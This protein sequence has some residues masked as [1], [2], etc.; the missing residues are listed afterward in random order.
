[1]KVEVLRGADA[2]RA[3]EDSAFRANWKSLHGLCPWS[4]VFQDVSFATTWYRV[5]RDVYEPVV[6]AGREVGGALSGLFLL[7]RERK[8]GALVHAGEKHAE[9]QTWISRPDRYAFISDAL[10]AIKP[11]AGGSTLQLRYVPSTLPLEPLTSSGNWGWRTV[12]WLEERGIADLTKA[13]G[14]ASL[15]D[16]SRYRYRMRRIGALGPVS[17]RTVTTREELEP[18]LDQ[19]IA[20]CDVRQGAINASFPFH[21]D[22][23]K[24][25]LHLAMVDAPNL[26]HT[27]LLTAGQTLISSE[28]NFLERRSISLGLISHSPMQGKI[29]PGT[30]HLLLLAKHA[31]AEGFTSIDLTP[32]GEYKERFASFTD[33]TRVVSIQFSA[34]QAVRAQVRHFA[35]D[36]AKTHIRDMGLEPAAV[37]KQWVE[38]ISRVRRS[39]AGAADLPNGDHSRQVTAELHIFR[40]PSVVT[41]S[42]KSKIPT[43]STPDLR[44]DEVADLLLPDPSD[45]TLHERRSELRGALARF[46][47]GAQLITRVAND[48]VTNAAWLAK[49]PGKAHLGDAFLDRELAESATLIHAIVGDGEFLADVIQFARARNPKGELSVAIDAA[50]V[51]H[52]Q[53]IAALGGELGERIAPRSS[54]DITERSAASDSAIEQQPS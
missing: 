12:N 31:A 50:D 30:L 29:S 16:S 17:F 35:A 37:K 22:P 51:A 36:K 28:I 52:T 26:L 18:W 38:R 20:F 34:T 54:D 4:T 1:M 41:N 23:L 40:L 14:I 43:S 42:D 39:I 24:R 9:Y 21:D 53:Q 5:Y 11:H 33:P 27:T 48:R 47:R 32:G 8:T 25:E 6:A 45:A 10:D 7:A 2:H 49:G 13:D 46:E 3:L 44:I 15:V 19:I